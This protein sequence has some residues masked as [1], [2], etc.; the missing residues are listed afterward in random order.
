[1]M[2]NPQNPNKS[3]LE[4]S[5]IASLDPCINVFQI[6]TQAYCTYVFKCFPIQNL[7]SALQSESLAEMYLLATF[8]FLILIIG[9]TGKRTIFV[10][11]QNK[12]N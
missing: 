1:M 5:D 10:F 7:H 8:K 4:T 6:H 9:E 11:N 12:L 2:P 3:L